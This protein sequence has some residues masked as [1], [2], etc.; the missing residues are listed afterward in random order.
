ML[1]RKRRRGENAAMRTLLG[2]PVVLLLVGNAFAQ[3][4]G[5]VN[6]TRPPEHE[7]L[8]YG[9]KKLLPG[10]IGDG[11]AEPEDH[12]PRDIV[13]EVVSVKNTKPALRSELTAEVRLQNTGTRSMEI[14]WSTEFSTIEKGES[15]VALRWDEG[16]FEFTLEDKQGR[17]VLLK[18]LTG[19]V[20]GSKFSAGSELTI[21]PGEGITAVVKFM[22][23]EEFLIIYADK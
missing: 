23:E 13:V 8:P 4:I 15:P 7:A 19:A 6:L 18:S 3:Q 11:I 12:V 20:Y 9:C 10:T 5:S 2:F 21:K 1:A 22:L 16:T 17:K 14:P